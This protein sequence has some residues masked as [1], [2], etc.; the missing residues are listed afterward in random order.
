MQKIQGEG[1]Q[2]LAAKCSAWCPKGALC[3]L[4]AKVT[5]QTNAVLRYLPETSRMMTT[6]VRMT[7]QSHSMHGRLATERTWNCWEMQWRSSLSWTGFRL[8]KLVNV[9]CSPKQPNSFSISFK[10]I[11]LQRGRERL[12][13][14]Q[15]RARVFLW[16]SLHANP[17]WLD[18]QIILCTIHCQKWKIVYGNAISFLYFGS[19]PLFPPALQTKLIFPHSWCSPQ[20]YGSS[21]CLIKLLQI[22]VCLLQLASASYQLLRRYTSVIKESDSLLWENFRT[23]YFWANKILINRN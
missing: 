23:V 13:L 17:G 20:Q 9:W 15:N 10:K 1:I 2:N 12:L 19:S 5:S 11:K 16:C 7:R 21:F 3:L 22:P 6:R 4:W 14:M 8:W 18:M